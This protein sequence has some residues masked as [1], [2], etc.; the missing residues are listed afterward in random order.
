MM[1][2]PNS[3]QINAAKEVVA[4]YGRDYRNTGTDLHQNTAVMAILAILTNQ[5]SRVP[6][7][8][9]D[10]VADMDMD[11]GEPEPV[12]DATG[13]NEEIMNAFAAMKGIEAGLPEGM[14]DSGL[15]KTVGLRV[16]EGSAAYLGVMAGDYVLI[17]VVNSAPAEP[18]N[19]GAAKVDFEAMTIDAL[20]TFATENNVDLTGMSKKADIIAALREFGF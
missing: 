15:D 7:D 11:M 6:A 16:S 4:K 19:D 1:L 13:I 2:K 5:I 14:D 10:I 12:E 3:A 20:R 17:D 8:Y 9:R 18:N